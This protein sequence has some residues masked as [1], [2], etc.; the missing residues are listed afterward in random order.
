[1][2]FACF[3]PI[4]QFVIKKFVFQRVLF[5]AVRVEGNRKRKKKEENGAYKI[6]GEKLHDKNKMRLTGSS[7]FSKHFNSKDFHIYIEN[8]YILYP[9]SYN[10]RKKKKSCKNENFHRRRK[11]KDEKK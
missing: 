10:F 8:L 11:R 3:F 4:T 2:L 7:Y 6:K 9:F 5:N 1:M